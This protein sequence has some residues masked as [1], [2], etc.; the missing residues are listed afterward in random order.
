MCLPTAAAIGLAIGAASQVTSYVGQAS[1]ADALS[2]YQDQNYQ[3]NRTAAL[4]SQNRS[5]IAAV[6]RRMQE[7][8]AAAQEIQSITQET[9]TA[10]SIARAQTADRGVTGLSVSDLFDQFERDRLTYVGDVRRNDQFREQEF[11]DQLL[12]LQNQT[13]S[14]IESALPRPIQRPNPLNLLFGLGSVG[15]NTYQ[16]HTRYNA[17]TGKRE[18]IS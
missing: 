14:R 6:Q 10:A 16:A 18:W 3:L 2:S 15:L 4:Q 1:Q 13:Q 7:R 11:R 5:Y 12:G 8:E 17:Q 9:R